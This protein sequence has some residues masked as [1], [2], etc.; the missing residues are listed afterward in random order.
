MCRVQ[1]TFGA[2]TQGFE[3][4]EIRVSMKETYAWNPRVLIRTEPLLSLSFSLS[5]GRFRFA[6]ILIRRAKIDGIGCQLAKKCGLDVGPSLSTRAARVARPHATSGYLRYFCLVSVCF[7]KLRAV[8]GIARSL[9]SFWQ[10]KGTDVGIS[11]LPRFKL[12]FPSK[13][14]FLA[15]NMFYASRSM[16]TRGHISKFT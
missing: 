14:P 2:D 16:G 5:I 7:V 11:S 8:M 9:H 10:K 15:V 3:H 1:R 12:T 4:W 13:T 6:I